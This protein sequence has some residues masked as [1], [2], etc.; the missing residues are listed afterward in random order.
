MIRATLKSNSART[1]LF[2]LAC[3]MMSPEVMA[4]RGRGSETDLLRSEAV[5]AELGLSDETA[6][7]LQELKAASEFDRD[8]FAKASQ[9]IREA[10]TDEEKNRLRQE[11]GD[12]IQAQRT[13]FQDKAPALLSEAERAKLRGLYL[14][15][16]GPR[17]LASDSIA[18]DYGLTDEQKKKLDELYGQRRGAARQLD[19]NTSDEDR[20]KFESEWQQKYLA[21]LTPEQKSRFEKELSQAPAPREQVASG[22]TRDSSAAPSAMA[23]SSTDKPAGATTAPAVS[24]KPPEGETATLSFGDAAGGQRRIVDEFS[25]N[26]KY[27]PWD[28]VLQM[29]ADATGL[30]LD[31]NKVPPGTFSHLDDRK[32]DAKKALDIMN[33]YLLRKGFGMFQKDHFLIV[34]NLDDGIP[35]SLLRDVTVEE[36]LAVG[37]N[38]AVGDNELVNVPIEISEMD[39]AKAAQEIEPLVGPW[40][41]MIAL[42]ESRLLIVT[43]IGSNLR[44]IHRLLTEAMSKSKPDAL[45]FNAYPLKHMDAE[46][47]EIQV[48]TQFGMRQNVENVTSAAQEQSRMRARTQSRTRGS[49]PTPQANSAASSEESPIQIASDLRLNSLLVTGTAKQHALVKEILAFVD[50]G[51]GPD[52]K[53]LARGRKGTYLEVY[54]VKSSDARE[55]ASTLSAMNMPGVTVVNEDAR[56]GRLHIMASERQ[57]QEVAMLIRQLD[58]AGSIGSVAVIPLA[59]MDPVSAAA[60]LRSLFYSDGDDAPTIETDLYGRRLIVRGSIDH[61]TQIKQVLADL[62]EDGSGVRDRGDGGTVR[63]LSMQGRDPQDFLK[64][65]KANWDANETTKLKIMELEESGPVKSRQTSDGELPLEGERMGPAAERPRE[66]D[67][68]PVS[69]REDA[70]PEK[71]SPNVPDSEVTQAPVKR[72]G[73]GSN[74]SVSSTGSRNKGSAI[75]SSALA[76]SQS[77]LFA[78]RDRSTGISSSSTMAAQRA[79]H[80]QTRALWSPNAPPDEEADDDTSAKAADQSSEDDKPLEIIVQGDDLILS[81]SNEKELDRLED[82][83]DM[84]QQTIPFKPEYTQY[85]LKSADALEA[86]DMLS[87]FFPSSSVASTTSSMTGG[88]MLGSLAGG[89][90][91]LGGSLMDATGLSGLG[92]VSNSLKIIPDPRTNSLFL[93]G[94]PI[95]VKDAISL[96]KVLDSNDGPDSLKDMQ[97]RKILVDYADVND[98]KNM[99]D[100]LFKTYL[101]AQSQGR[102]SQQQNPL[103]AMFGG[104]GRGG[105]GNEAAQVRMHL[106]VDQQNSLILVNSS[107]ELFEAVESVVKDLDTAAKDAN[108]MI[109]VIQLKN[110]DAT[111]IQQSLTSLLP[112]VSVSSSST[113]GRSSSSNSGD[114][115]ARGGNDDNNRAAEAAQ[116]AQ[117]E[118]FMRAMQQ[119]GAQGG[120]GGAQRGGGGRGGFGGGGFGGGGRGGG[121]GGR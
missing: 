88:S 60:T 13:M 115:N 30:T 86:S 68:P 96:L 98:V 54:E 69:Q 72:S 62:G 55:V 87:Q 79:E 110:A 95:M 28:Q 40:G 8:Y 90:S 31:L 106:T 2:A 107:L 75:S 102:N 119:R 57:H 67:A 21:V 5:Y 105:S 65:L 46:E 80:I 101:E 117:R 11:M 66:S 74:F 37:P 1:F 61:I 12:M 23:Q 14:K 51:E 32:Y 85:F 26:F 9:Q 89:F 7:K 52:G 91:D 76:L 84:L 111:M 108:R 94:P 19:S 83:F 42:T 43:D 100:D 103:A 18:E 6:K 48:L 109:R 92:G 24:N 3:A 4:Q 27:A 29:F 36:L 35:P 64:L 77:P 112:R 121:R 120:G 53:P 97:P 58:G 20:E 41:S 114:N 81:S 59:Q 78:M 34:I 63:R 16:S 73:R 82:L 39:T 25:F 50:V 113:S 49:T 22:D 71:V 118:A 93:T 56:N 33:G 17:G 45:V 15:N 47:A 104:G 116:Q 10:K 99:L 44:R 70:V 38:Q